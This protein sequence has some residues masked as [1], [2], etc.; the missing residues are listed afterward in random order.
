MS[1]WQDG[2]A[3]QSRTTFAAEFADDIVLDATALVTPIEGRELVA[4]VMATASSIYETLEF[5]DSAHAGSTSYLQWRE[6]AFGGMEIRGVTILDRDGDGKVTGAAI[7]HRPLP[8][9]LRFS[10]ELRDRL[11]GVLSGEHF[12]AP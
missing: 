2:F 10:A 7:H 5:T 3:Q 1:G 12:V 8:M 9:V 11:S 6:T 4:I